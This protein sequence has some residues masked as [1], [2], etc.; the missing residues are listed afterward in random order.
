LRIAIALIILFSRLSSA[1]AGWVAPAV[2]N[3]FLPEIQIIDEAG[4][5]HS[6]HAVLDAAGSGPVLMVPAYTRC[7]GSC[8]EV[9]EGLKKSLA[10]IE[11]EQNLRVALFSFDDMDS[12]ADLRRFREHHGI[13][14]DWLILRAPSADD[15][16]RFLDAFSFSLMKSGTEFSHPSEVLVLT[17]DLRW[18]GSLTGSSLNAETVQEGLRKAR[19]SRLHALLLRPEAWILLGVLGLSACFAVIFAMLRRM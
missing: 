10:A 1:Y 14:A 9:V 8:P 4:K 15:A 16:R 7:Q 13:P 5:Q 19:A 2:Q 6:I 11:G 17:G 18:S 3:Q 12:A